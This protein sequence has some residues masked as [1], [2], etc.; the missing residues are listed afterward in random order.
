M[1]LIPPQFK[2]TFDCIPPPYHKPMLTLDHIRAGRGL[3]SVP[4]TTVQFI[5]GGF[6][7]SQK[8]TWK[9]V[10]ELCELGFI[11]RILPTVFYLGYK[12]HLTPDDGGKEN[13]MPEDSMDPSL[14]GM[15]RTV[16]T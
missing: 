5:F 8:E 10:A 14:H 13:A 3:D 12:S 15:R 11:E 16:R 1:D 2:K 7:F 9:I 6:R 4:P